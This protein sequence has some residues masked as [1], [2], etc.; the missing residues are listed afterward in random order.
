MVQTHRARWG[1]REDLDAAARAGDLRR[2]MWDSS[3]CLESVASLL[4]EVTDGTRLA[5]R[6]E[7]RQTLRSPRTARHMTGTLPC[8]DDQA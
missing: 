5:D 1:L 7:D 4:N 8:P 2:V 3:V 6:T